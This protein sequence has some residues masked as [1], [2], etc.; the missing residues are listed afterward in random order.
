GRV[1]AANF[2]GPDR[3]LGAQIMAVSGPVART[4]DDI[5]LGLEAM[6]AQD[7]RDPWWVPVP[8]TLPPLPRRAALSTHPDGMETAPEIVAE[9]T[10]AAEALRAAGWVVEEV[11]IPPLRKAAQQNILLWSGEMR[12]TGGK[13]IAD[14]DDPDANHVYKMLCEIAGPL[15]EETLLDAVQYRVTLLREWQAFLTEYPVLLC[16]VCGELPFPAH[17]DVESDASF[18]RCYE[19]QLMQIGIPFLGLPGLTVTTGL[20]GRAPVGVQVI[21]GRY[22]EDVMI[23]AGRII[24]AAGTP[25][26]PVDPA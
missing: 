5:A 11:D 2:S 1:P 16:P 13:A 20:V 10:R 22:R 8:L 19:A 12:R 21:S 3:L 23:E 26:S 4:M 24:E 15:T 17:L 25:P 14:E 6:S 18:M 7:L 9:L